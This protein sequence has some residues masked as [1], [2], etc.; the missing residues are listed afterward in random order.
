MLTADSSVYDIVRQ[1]SAEQ[2]AKYIK[3]YG[4]ALELMMLSEPVASNQI[5]SLCSK[6]RINVGDSTYFLPGWNPQRLRSANCFSTAA[7][8]YQKANVYLV[9]ERLRA[10]LTE[11]VAQ[12]TNR[13]S[14]SKSSVS[15]N[16]MFW[17][18]SETSAFV[19]GTKRA[20]IFDVLNPKVSAAEIVNRSTSLTEAVRVYNPMFIKGFFRCYEKALFNVEPGFEQFDLQPCL[21]IV[22]GGLVCE[23]LQVLSDC[24]AF[25]FSEPSITVV[26]IKNRLAKATDAGWADVMV[27]FVFSDMT[28]GKEGNMV[29]GEI[30]VRRFD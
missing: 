24:L 22:R 5:A 27:N 3:L 8:M 11:C 12:Q 20:G 30:Q 29:V 1:K 25:L 26:R 13:S 14:S 10:L 9:Q 17:L 19:H 21:D 15:K 7:E 23:T 16:K 2:S 4:A 18:A 28:E 6:N